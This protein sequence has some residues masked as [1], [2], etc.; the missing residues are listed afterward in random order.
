MAR[1]VKT[2]TISEHL[3]ALSRM[4]QA[5]DQDDRFGESQRRQLRKKVDELVGVLQDIDT[6]RVAGPPR[7][8]PAR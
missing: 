8:Q 5:F 3:L 2:K 4:R 6:G 1:P 7:A